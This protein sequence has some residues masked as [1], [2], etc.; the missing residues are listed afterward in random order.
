MVYYRGSSNLAAIYMV[1]CSGK[2][3]EAHISRLNANLRKFVPAKICPHFSL[4]V[5]KLARALLQQYKHH[6][7]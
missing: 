6:S 3:L 2:F 7:W 5:C 4:H 1:L